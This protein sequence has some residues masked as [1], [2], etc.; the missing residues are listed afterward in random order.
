[1]RGEGLGFWNQG[2]ELLHEVLHIIAQ[3]D[4]CGMPFGDE[5]HTT[6]RA[7]VWHPVET[8]DASMPYLISIAFCFLMPIR[9]SRMRLEMDSKGMNASETSSS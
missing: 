5:A 9:C 1:M 8:I 2:T 4:V 3:R 6:L 7:G